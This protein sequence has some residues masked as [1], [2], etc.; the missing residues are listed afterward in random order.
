MKSYTQSIAL[1]N[2]MTKVPSSDT[3][4]TALLTQLWND[5][6]RTICSIRSGKWWFLQ[7]L[8]TI[9]TV[10]SQ[11]SYA[12]PAKVRKI[13]DVYVTVGST[14]Y[15][16]QPV[17]S[18]EAWNRILSA[19]LGES[20]VPMFYFVQDNK[21]L[22]QPI[23]S[24]TAGTITVRGRKSVPDLT[25]DDDT[26]TVTAIANGATA[27]TISS[28]GLVSMAGKYLRI[29]ALAT[30]AANAGDGQWYE[31]ASA[32]AT[33]IT[34]VAPYEGVTIAA[35]TA[36][37]TV[38][39]MTP[40]PDAYD[41]APIYRTV[42][43]YKQI[44]DPVHPNVA[45]TYWKLYDGGQEAGLSAMVGGLVGQMLES[46]GESIEGAFVAPIGSTSN[47]SYGAPY[48]LPRQDASGF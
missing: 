13:I 17:Y 29:T 3:T 5:S 26:V 38:A 36:T 41:M 40:I 19:Q 20:D 22:I 30:G 11:G 45:T 15:T 43:L 32:T 18:P 23:P 8:T 33:T 1:L 28:G 44:N 7:T 34:L 9:A 24:S 10:A 35:G 48:Y 27:V 2:S 47:S 31:I 39:E 16:P 4:N 25:V 37:A 12:I 46:E 21:I 6:V 14:V 42:A